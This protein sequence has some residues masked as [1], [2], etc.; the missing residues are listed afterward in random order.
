M[1]VTF[2]EPWVRKVGPTVE[3]KF[4]AGWSGDLPEDVATAAIEARAAEADGP[5]PPRP[6]PAPPVD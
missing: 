2:S 1:R 6:V 4:P 3:Q 5:K